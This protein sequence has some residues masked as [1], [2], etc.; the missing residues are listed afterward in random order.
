[1]NS[2]TGDNLPLGTTA[3]FARMHKW[4]QRAL[5]VCL[6]A[7]VF[8]GAFAVPLLAIWYGAP[9]LSFL[10]ICNEFQKIRYADDSREC[11]YPYPL[12]GPPEA[13]GQTTAQ[14]EWGIQPKPKY[15]RIGFREL[16][17]IRD[18]RLARQQA[19][20]QQRAEAQHTSV[21]R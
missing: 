14:D 9:T 7:L 17:R 12:F 19:E 13:A 18:E 6:V 15:K 16:V 5:I 20:S 1:M 3:P 8:E 10:E 4:L 21:V 2:S 11:I